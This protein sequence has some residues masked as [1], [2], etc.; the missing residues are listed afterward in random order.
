MSLQLN[1][2]IPLVVLTLALNACD[3]TTL[4]PDPDPDPEFSELTVDASAGWAFVN[5]DDEQAVTVTDPSTSDVWDIGFFA[6][7][8]MLNGGSA[9]PGDIQGYCLCQND[10]AS[11]ADIMAMTAE[12]ELEDFDSV[13]ETAVPADEN[14]WQSEALDPVIQDWYSY[15]PQTHVVSPEPDAVYLLKL[16]GDAYGVLHVIEIETP[17]MAHAGTVT[18]EFA[19]QPTAGDA[20]GEPDTL[21]ADLSSGRVYLD[22]VASAFGS[23]AEWDLAVEGYTFMTNGGVSGDGG[24][25]AVATSE[26][27]DDV[28]SASGA[29]ASVYAGDAF[30]GV[31]AEHA[32]Y[33]YN[34]DGDHTIFP[35]FDVYLLRSGASVW[36]L[37]ILN[38]YDD[39]G[40]SRRISFRYAHLGS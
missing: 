17:A 22:L 8:V 26:A 24:V 35:T 36:K 1:R 13:D 31:F 18:I 32:W 29:P 3:E 16:R 28:T 25:G 14:D 40:E 21:V 6:T 27:F 12:A 15:N 2:L 30:G 19:V 5:L 20:L 38:Y 9:G 4:E 33:K 34:L 39:A 11:D 10:G 23:D 37:Q 7:S